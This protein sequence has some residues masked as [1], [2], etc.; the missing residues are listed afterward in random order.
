[1]SAKGNA[2]IKIQKVQLD[3]NG[4]LTPLTRS[5]SSNLFEAFD[6]LFSN[7]VVNGV[8]ESRE[9]NHIILFVDVIRES[10]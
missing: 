1:M 4:S 7:P 2:V 10:K 5:G 3:I 9:S 8:I 6:E